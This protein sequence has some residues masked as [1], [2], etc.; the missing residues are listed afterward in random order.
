MATNC[1]LVRPTNVVIISARSI[2]LRYDVGNNSRQLTI[3][4]G[5][6]NRILNAN[7]HRVRKFRNYF[8][9]EVY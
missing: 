9:Y 2:I 6:A 7:K 8:K 3:P 1:K 4:Q 5:V